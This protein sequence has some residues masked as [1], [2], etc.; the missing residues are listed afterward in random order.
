MWFQ[1]YQKYSVS[2]CHWRKNQRYSR[3]IVTDIF[4]VLSMIIKYSFF[5]NKNLILIWSSFHQSLED[6]HFENHTMRWKEH[7]HLFTHS[8]MKV[9]WSRYSY[10]P[11]IRENIYFLT[12]M[13]NVWL[14]DWVLHLTEARD[15]CGQGLGQ[16]HTLPDPDWRQ[17][18]GGE[19]QLFI[20][21][22]RD[23][24]LLEASELYSQHGNKVTSKWGHCQ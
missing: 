16:S 4:E 20:R 22:C 23:D 11:L 1:N 3:Q 8:D 13:S 19:T 2:E 17:S 5:C 14:S 21:C 6:L 10:F 7:L 9:E 12:E 24:T 18:Q 15:D